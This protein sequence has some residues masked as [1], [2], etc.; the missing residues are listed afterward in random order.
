MFKDIGATASPSQM[1]EFLQC[2]FGPPHVR[3]LPDSENIP[4]RFL[5]QTQVPIAENGGMPIPPPC[6][7]LIGIYLFYENWSTKNSGNFQKE[8]NRDIFGRQEQGGGP[9]ISKNPISTICESITF[10]PQ[11][12]SGK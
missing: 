6:G 12:P 1:H 7:L 4:L 3:A 9:R 11:H 10:I 5:C 2:L 8:V